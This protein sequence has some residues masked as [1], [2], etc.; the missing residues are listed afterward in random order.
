MS[1]SKII[2]TT[3][4]P[5]PLGLLAFGMTT[6]LLNLHNAGF[7][8]FDSMILGMGFFFGGMAQIIAGMMEWKK[9][10]TFATTAFISYGAFWLVLVG[11]I[12]LPKTDLGIAGPAKDAGMATFLALWGVFTLVMFRATFYLNRA[13]Q[14]VFGTLALLFF[15]L[16][17]GDIS[18]IASITVM[19]G[20]EGV[21]C[22]SIAMYAGLAQV[23]NEVA[24]KEVWPLDAPAFKK[25][26]AKK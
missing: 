8:P 18:G 5:A 20:F 15:M 2:D 6:I 10:N 9:G 17:L 19:A 25:K 16:A 12:V 13:L 23:M 21:I 3:G 7:F 26:K 11:L 22:G 24:G 4:N 1:E 14:Y